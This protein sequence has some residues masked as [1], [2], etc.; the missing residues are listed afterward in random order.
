[1]GNKITLSEST[2]TLIPEGPAIFEIL[3]VEYTEKTGKME[4]KMKTTDGLK[5]TEKFQ[6]KSDG[7]TINEKALSA[8]SFFARAVLDD[9]TIKEI[10]P[11]DLVG[12]FFS[13]D[14]K[15][16]VQ[17]SK[18]DPTKDVTWVRLENKKAYFGAT[19]TKAVAAEPDDDDDELPDLSI[20]S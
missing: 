8:F 5:H 18:N 16:D 3:A 9:F 13:C 14:V 7:K 11:D 6:L 17:P 2:F 4:V 20:L 19:P 12:H 10:D 1:M 15:H